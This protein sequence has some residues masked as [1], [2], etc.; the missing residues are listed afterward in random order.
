MQTDC[1]CHPTDLPDFPQTS[2]IFLV[3][4]TT[5]SSDRTQSNKPWLPLIL[6]LRLWSLL[7]CATPLYFASVQMHRRL[8]LT[9]VT[10]PPTPTFFKAAMNRQSK[11]GQI[12]TLR[13]PED[14]VETITSYLTF[15]YSNNLPT[16][17]LTI[18]VPALDDWMMLAKLYVL[19]ERFLDSVIRDAAVREILRISTMPDKNGACHFF[20]AAASNMFF[21]H[22]PEGS[23]ICQLIIDEHVSA[24]EECW[25]VPGEDHPVLVLSLSRALM[26][27]AAR[28]QP[29]EEFRNHQLQAEDYFV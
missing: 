11:E 26:E 17:N 19:G 16:S 12:R 20:P 13:L 6:V 25:L 21:D 7:L 27:K 1:E 5:I 18:G 8:P 10:S 22:L 2:F 3:L 29:Y 14:N 9:R 4:F 24:G 28:H 15:T 23:P